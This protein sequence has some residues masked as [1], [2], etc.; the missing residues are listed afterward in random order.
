MPVIS[1]NDR[2]VEIA[3]NGRLVENLFDDT[4]SETFDPTI[5]VEAN[6]HDGD[7]VIISEGDTLVVTIH[8]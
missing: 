3:L 5:A 2:D 4:G 8:V 7:L 6:M 1:V